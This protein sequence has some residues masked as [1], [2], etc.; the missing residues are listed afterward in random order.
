MP[1]VVFKIV[2]FI[3]CVLS[4]KQRLVLRDRDGSTHKIDGTYFWGVLLGKFTFQESAQGLDVQ[5][6]LP[7]QSRQQPV[8]EAQIV[9]MALELRDQS[10]RG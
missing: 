10:H 7:Q 1:N 8:A 9:S 3:V 2:V 6:T 4:V 5:R